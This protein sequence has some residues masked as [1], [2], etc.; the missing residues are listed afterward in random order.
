MAN[1]EPTSPPEARQGFGKHIR[2]VIQ[3]QLNERESVPEEFQME[4]LSQRRKSIAEKDFVWWLRPIKMRDLSNFTREL[5]IILS[6]GTPI[7]QAL[8]NIGLRTHNTHL[9]E[10]V[11]RVGVMVENGEAFWHALSQ[12]PHVF[13]QLYVSSIRAGEL[14]GELDSVLKRLA[15]HTERQWM[16][17]RRVLSALAYPALVVVVAIVVCG[18]LSTM[19]IPK[20]A[21]M[22]ESFNADMPPLTNAIA[23]VVMWLPKNWYWLLLGLLALI[24]VYRL[25]IR[26]FPARLLADRIKLRAPVIGN[27]THKLIAARFARTFSMLFESG[28]PIT[29]TLAICRSTVDNEVVALKV[30]DIR[31]G[32][33]NGKSLEAS[34]KGGDVFPPMLTDMVAVGEQAGRLDEVLPQTA[35]VYDNEADITLST[36]GS[37]IEPLLII[38]IAL[39]V[40]LVFVGFFLPY[41]NLLNSAATQI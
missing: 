23:S 38:V 6:I 16:A 25:A 27:V 37:I 7:L 40:L 3:E 11:Y 34:M 2:Q 35:D 19:V 28:V 36:I 10:V 12:F 31:E 17:R 26:T 21:E 24:V 15:D 4:E 13:P 1:E 41:I 8:R 9:R 30:D 33:E 5:S 32:V 14:S 29:E 39:L 18:V 20:F 22:F